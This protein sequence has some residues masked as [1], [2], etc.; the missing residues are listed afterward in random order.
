ML[1]PS[2]R[3]WIASELARLERKMDEYVNA[4]ERADRAQRRQDI[5]TLQSWRAQAVAEFQEIHDVLDPI[6]QRLT[7]VSTLPANA[8]F[9]SIIRKTGDAQLYLG[10]G[11]SQP[12][13]KLVPVPL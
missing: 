2:E 13:S 7:V 11:P 12:L 5:E 8:P 1:E 10:N 3:T 6:V 9:G 4:D